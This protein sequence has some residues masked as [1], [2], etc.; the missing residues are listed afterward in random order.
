MFWLFA[1][2]RD[3]WR[4]GFV[5]WLFAGETEDDGCS[6]DDFVPLRQASGVVFSWICRGHVLRLPAWRNTR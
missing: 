3:F 1:D 5:F 6:V 2:E 4:F